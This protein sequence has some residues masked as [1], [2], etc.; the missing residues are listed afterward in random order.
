MKILFISHSFP[1]ILGG[2]ENQNFQLAKALEKT[3]TVQI[4]KNS[5]GKFW[6]PLFVPWAFLKSLFLMRKSDVCLLGSGV[7]APIGLLIKIIYPRK[8]V[9]CITHALDIIFAQKPGFLSKIYSKINIPSL[10][11]MDKLFMVG[12][13]T[14][15]EAV[16]TGIKSNNCKFIPN[17]INKEEL[18]EEH[19]RKELSLIFGKNTNDRKVILRLGRFVPHKGTSWFIDKVMPKLPENVV[20]IAAGGRVAR[21]TAGDKDDFINSEKA[22]IKNGL[23]KRVRLYPAIPQKDLKI[24]LNTVDLVVSPNIKIP[25]SMEGFGI[26][27][28]EAGV[29]ERVVLASDIEGLVDAIKGGENGKLIK[30]K[31][32]KNWIKEVKKIIKLK[33][34]ELEKMG[35]KAGKYVEKNYAWDKIAQKYIKEM[36]K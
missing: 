34:S 35:K 2:I 20:L 17:G 6:L 5:Q 16:K 30:H 33:K 10:K 28:I 15:E 11:K 3:E 7:L 31:N 24:L 8:R 1:P 23:E 36:K 18:K 14:I 9:Y 32:A 21:N 19:S 27:V 4:I 29:C 25:G 22:I 13:A 12:N 26:N